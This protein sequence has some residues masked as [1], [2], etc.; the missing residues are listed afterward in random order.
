MLKN[1]VSLLFTVY[2]VM[3]FANIFSS[4]VPQI[5]EK[6]IMQFIYFYTEPYLNIFRKIIPPLGGILDIS[7]ILAFFILRL[8]Q[9]FFIGFFR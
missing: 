6:K 7:P 2:T 3:L 5:R 4:W 8:V 9:K 1:I